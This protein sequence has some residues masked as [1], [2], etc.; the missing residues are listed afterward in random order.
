[1]HV[2]RPGDLGEADHLDIDIPQAVRQIG[3]MKYSVLVGGSGEL[4]FSL[5]CGDGDTGHGQRSGLDRAT[6]LGR[7]HYGCCGH[8]DKGRAA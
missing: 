7:H 5:D 3:E 8:I 6:I 2:N 4:F 1:L